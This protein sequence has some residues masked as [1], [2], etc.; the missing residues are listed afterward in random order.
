MVYS[1]YTHQP[2]L[3]GT[4]ICQALTL[5]FI[6]NEKM[7]QAR[8]SRKYFYQK[9]LKL[10]QYPE[11]WLDKNNK[12][13]QTEKSLLSEVENIVDGTS[14]KIRIVSGYQRKLL[15]PAGILH[16]YLDSRVAFL[17][18]LIEINQASFQE[19]SL[20][21]TLFYSHQEMNQYLVNQATI[22]QLMTAN[23]FSENETVY[24]VL[25]AKK[26]DKNCISTCTQR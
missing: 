5:V 6:G 18:G 2:L 1:S 16:N 7:A 14:G 24:I 8:I 26:T 21:K 11:L 12:T 22:K 25:R 10:V 20:L 23:R 13:H 3:I 17:N 4:E 19:S 9:L 15:K